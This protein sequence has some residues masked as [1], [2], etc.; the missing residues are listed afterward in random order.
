[1]LK[2]VRQFPQASRGIVPGA[3]VS[4]ITTALK[5]IILSKQEL[6]GTNFDLHA[7][8]WPPMPLLTYLFD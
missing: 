7:C 1:M 3:E 4:R 6:G 5:G 2:E 8:D